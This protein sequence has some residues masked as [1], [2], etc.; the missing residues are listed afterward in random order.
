MGFIYLINS[1]T[2]DKYKIGVSKNPPNRKKE[3]QTGNPQDLILVDYYESENYQK[4]ETI[5]HRNLKHKKYIEDDFRNLKGEW[6]ILTN[7]DVLNFKQKCKKIEDSI[8][9]LKENS[10]FDITKIL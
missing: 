7:E 9:Y 3:L 1:G 2:T 4:I 8:E 6:F 5:L 10:T